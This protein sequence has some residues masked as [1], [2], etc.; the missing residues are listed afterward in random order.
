MEEV[1]WFGKWKENPLQWN[2]INKLA[3]E[4]SE[5]QD[6]N[7]ELVECVEAL[8]EKGSVKCQAKKN[9]QLGRKQQLRKIW[10]LEKQSTVC[11]VVL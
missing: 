11:P 3:E 2:E 7:K 5:L 10:H 1:C 9:H 4:I 8:A 6:V